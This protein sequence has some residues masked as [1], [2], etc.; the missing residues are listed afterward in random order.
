MTTRNQVVTGIITVALVGTVL[1]LLF[2]P[3]TGRETREIVGMRTSAIKTK[4]GDY[5]SVIR[6][7]M[8]RGEEV[9][10][11]NG[12]SHPEEISL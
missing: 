5:F 11:L 3:K 12:N 6:S 1:G 2:A 10:S 4:A 9:E 8:K 7:K